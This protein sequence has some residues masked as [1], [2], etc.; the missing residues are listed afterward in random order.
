MSSAH[1]IKSMKAHFHQI[2]LHNALWNNV[3]LMKNVCWGGRVYLFEYV[4]FLVSLGSTMRRL[5]GLQLISSRQ[6]E[7]K[8]IVPPLAH[9]CNRSRLKGPQGAYQAQW[10]SKATAVTPLQQQQHSES[11]ELS[12]KSGGCFLLFNKLR[13]DP[14][15]RLWSRQSL[16]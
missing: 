5:Q 13:N 15:G 14:G 11:N 1:S 16:C 6:K 9:L 7:K 8:N 2:V 12:I 3:L 4:P 10:V